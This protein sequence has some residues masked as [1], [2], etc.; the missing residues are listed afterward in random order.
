L[1][2]TVLERT[3]AQTSL[4]SR[5][6]HQINE[7]DRELDDEI[8]SSD[9][10][11]GEMELEPVYLEEALHTLENPTL[12]MSEYGRAAGSPGKGLYIPVLAICSIIVSIRFQKEGLQLLDSDCGY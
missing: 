12:G 6:N 4:V 3:S 10:L 2:A 5:G 11:P 1:D 7:E 8:L 9:L